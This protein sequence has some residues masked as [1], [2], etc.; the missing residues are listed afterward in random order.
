MN[1]S[2]TNKT[3][4]LI[5]TFG[6]L[7]CESGHKE[8]K[9]FELQYKGKNLSLPIDESTSN[10]SDGLTY[11]AQGNLLFSLNWIENGF[12]IYDLDEKRKIADVTFDYE[13]PNGVLDV[14]GIFVQSLDSIFLFNQLE[15]QVTLID[16]SGKIKSK[17]KYQTPEKYSPAFV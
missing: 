15:S 11:F 3:I 16:S 9:F 12:Q 7:A 17:I 13:G 1:T 5:L 8:A 10:L 2:Y 6:L 14:M 4:L